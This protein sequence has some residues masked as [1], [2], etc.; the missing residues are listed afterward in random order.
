MKRKRKSSA[1]QDHRRRDSED[2]K[3]KKN[4]KSSSKTASSHQHLNELERKT[5]EKMHETTILQTKNEATK[6]NSENFNGRSIT[7]LSGEN[8]DH[9][10]LQDAEI[11][12]KIYKMSMMPTLSLNKLDSHNGCDDDVDDDDD[13]NG[14]DETSIRRELGQQVIEEV[15]N[16]FSKI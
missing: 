10:R 15:D 1:N 14:W 4:R 2:I 3:K 6:I 9:K 12:A 5:L 7:K 11:S 8:L 13:E 16:Y